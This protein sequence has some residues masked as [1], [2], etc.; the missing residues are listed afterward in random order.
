M[1]LP[2]VGICIVCIF[3]ALL[4]VEQKLKK[5]EPTLSKFPSARFKIFMD[6]QMLTILPF[7]GFG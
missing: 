2:F 6:D 4:F 5:T 7:S 1:V 3:E